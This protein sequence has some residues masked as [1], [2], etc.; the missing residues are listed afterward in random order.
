MDITQSYLKE[1]FDY[2]EDGNLI[3]KK[4]IGKRSKHG[5]VA[6]HLKKSNGYICVG[7]K[8]KTYYAHR[9]VW[10]WHYGFL[11]NKDTDHINGIRTDNRVENLR[12]ATRSQNNMNKAKLVTNKSGI[13][14]VHFSKAA[15]K[16]TS[17]IK[18]NGKTIHLG[19]FENINEAAEARKKAELEHYGK[20]SPLTRTQND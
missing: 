18:I 11:P 4:P 5:E 3:W 10:F 19:L 1:I 8:T 15:S 12:E 16:W 14:G 6:G 13:H 9:L 2:R 20:F 7:I 17:Q